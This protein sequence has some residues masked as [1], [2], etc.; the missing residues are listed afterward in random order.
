M[1]DILEYIMGDELQEWYCYNYDTDMFN[2]RINSRGIQL[3]FNYNSMLTGD[4]VH[5]SWVELEKTATLLNGRF[6]TELA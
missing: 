5:R 2:E 6:S 4:Y 3:Q 1:T